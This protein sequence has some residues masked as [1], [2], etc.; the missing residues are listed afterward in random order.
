MLRFG[1]SCFSRSQSLLPPP[2]DCLTTNAPTEPACSE[3]QQSRAVVGVSCS[4]LLV[5][6]LSGAFALL[7]ACLSGAYSFLWPSTLWLHLSAFLTRAEDLLSRAVVDPSPSRH[8]MATFSVRADSAVLGSTVGESAPRRSSLSRESTALVATPI[9]T[10]TPGPASVAPRDPRDPRRAS[11]S[12]LQ[13]SHLSQT[14][15]V[16]APEARASPPVPEQSPAA[17]RQTETARPAS[18]SPLHRSSMPPPS[19]AAAYVF[20]SSGHTPTVAYTRSVGPVAGTTSQ[21]S[22]LSPRVM[23]SSA[24]DSSSAPP[25]CS[26]GQPWPHPSHEMSGPM[27]SSGPAPAGTLYGS[28]HSS[29]SAPYSASYSHSTAQPHT[30]PHHVRHPPG[31]PYSMA[32]S[33]SLSLGVAQSP[34]V[35]YL[36]CPSPGMSPAVGAEPRRCKCTYLYVCV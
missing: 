6:C 20:S 17:L 10:P 23:H 18:L 5:A 28:D 13:P 15:R 12:W 1:C 36:V 2:P 26:V 25:P 32:A 3:C 22:G 8:T 16:S 14:Q 29:Q 19:V 21:R 34:S 30:F 7:V 27:S 35:S 11:G 31:F 33:P 4:S 24:D 9:H